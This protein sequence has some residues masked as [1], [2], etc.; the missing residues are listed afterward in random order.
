MSV[1]RGRE[2]G[3]LP[4][5]PIASPAARPG[6]AA[7]I[8]RAASTA[9]RSRGSQAHKA[10]GPS[11]VFG[12]RTP[13]AGAEAGFCGRFVSTGG[14]GGKPGRCAWFFGLPLPPAGT[15][16]SPLLGTP[17]ASPSPRRPGDPA[18][19]GGS[20]QPLASPRSFW[21]FNPL[22]VHKRPT[23]HPMRRVLWAVWVK[24][25]AEREAPTRSMNLRP[26][27]SQRPPPGGGDSITTEPRSSSLTRMARRSTAS[28]LPVLRLTKSK[29]PRRSV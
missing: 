29:R 12:E 23:A 2:R 17:M 7:G 27:D 28:R 4:V 13:G 10:S 6:R 14:R 5:P 25:H 3:E 9:A 11:V 24:R 18:R 22:G 26:D 16:V 15:G 19:S 20:R 8:R 21:P 1:N